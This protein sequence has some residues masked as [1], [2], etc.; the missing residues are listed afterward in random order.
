MGGRG[1]G[2]A[3]NRGSVSE[4]CA[5]SGIQPERAQGLQGGGTRRRG[6]LGRG[7]D[8]GRGPSAHLA[9]SSLSCSSLWASCRASSSWAE[10]PRV[11]CSALGT[12]LS[13]PRR[14]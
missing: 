2:P 8:G 14:P 9:L 11:S 13:P 4:L 6:S 10:S 5:G 12:R 1:A 7:A 3:G